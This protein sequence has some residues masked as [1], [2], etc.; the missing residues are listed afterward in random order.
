MDIVEKATVK[1]NT[2]PWAGRMGVESDRVTGI[3]ASN[4]IG[5]STIA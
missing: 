2:A 1:D 5:V 4:R 3:P